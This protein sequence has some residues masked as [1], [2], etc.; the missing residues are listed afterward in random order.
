MILAQAFF[1]RN[2]GIPATGLALADID[3]YLTS[4][5]KATG[6]VAVIWNGA[7]NPTEELTNIGCYARAYN[8]DTTVTHN[9][10]LRA[11]YTGAVVL[12]VDHV[13]GGLLLTQEEVSDEVFATYTVEGAMTFEQM[14][15]I[16]L[17]V[18]AGLSAGGGGF[19][20]RFRDLANLKN[21]VTA[22]VD[23]QGNRLV[24]ALDGTP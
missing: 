12:D 9:Y 19:N 16:F 2:T 11:T 1:T 8:L 6:A 18:L 22:Q 23:I 24:I 3:L 21:R 4:R 7:Q 20:L 13:I 15:R 17:A 10:A 5:N 14:Q